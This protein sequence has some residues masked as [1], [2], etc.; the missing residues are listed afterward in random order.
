MK[1][2]VLLLAALLP[3]ALHAQP[4]AVQAIMQ[5][6]APFNEQYA[7][8]D[9]AAQQGDSSRAEVEYLQAIA[10]YKALP[11]SV[12]TFVQDRQGDPLGGLCYNLACV[13]SLQGKR[14]A[15]ESLSEAIDRDYLRNDYS[16]YDWMIRDPDLEYVRS[17]PAFGPLRERAAAQGDFMGMLRASASYDRSAPTDS[18]PRF[19]YASPDDP[20]LQRVRAHFGLDS[21]AGSGDELSRIL[22]LLHWAHR[23]VRHDGGSDN[24]TSRNA[25]DMVE[26]CRREGRGLN[27]RMMAQMLTECY[28]S[29]GIP[30]RFV[31]CLPREFVADCHVICAV[32]SQT[33]G[34]WLWIDPTFD[35]YVTN[36][37]GTPLGIREVR[38]RM[39]NGE[40]YLLNPEANW[41]FEIPQVKEEY[42]DLY[43]AKNLYYLVCTDRSE[44][45]TETR[46]EG[47]ERPHYIGLVPP[48]G[49]ASDADQYGVATSNDAWFWAAPDAKPGATD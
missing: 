40:P 30:A 11:D 5:A 34:R 10:L 31:T 36:E 26:L 24:P 21:V 15:L 9:E 37:H 42:L 4:A 18:L 28:L 44:F 29:L 46:V 17:L 19:R 7:R 2:L 27:C 3:L 14:E 12:R 35:A 32:W 43:M 16:A 8:G 41:N 6:L 25:I 38:E 1:R 23:T 49:Y 33:L 13:Q 39:R 47:K 45:D 22:N 48:P 20:D